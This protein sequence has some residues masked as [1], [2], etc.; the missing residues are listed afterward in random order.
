MAVCLPP[1]PW[2]GLVEK[3]IENMK[4]VFGKNGRRNFQRREKILE[5]GKGVMIKAGWVG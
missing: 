5:E 4:I 1:F 3:G 2:L